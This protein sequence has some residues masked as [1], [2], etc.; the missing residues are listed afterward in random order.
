MKKIVLLIVC[1]FVQSIFANPAFSDRQKDQKARGRLAKKMYMLPSDPK[2][3]PPKVYIDQGACPFE[4]CV[5]REWDVLKDTVLYDEPGGKKIVGK[6]RKG[7]KAQAVTGE[8]HTIPGIFVLVEQPQKGSSFKIGDVL[9][10]L[11]NQGEGY[12]KYWIK[13]KIR[14]LYIEQ[15]ICNQRTTC[16]G[17]V[18][19]KK[20]V[21]WT[22]IKLPD[23]KMGWV[24]MDKNFH[25]FDN[26]DS[27]G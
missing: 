16:Y 23:G 8:V 4:C 21:W 17:V 9:Y 25:N 13:G 1:L 27:C 24:Q 14:S 5:Y 19:E 26:M 15:N 7:A 22:Q 20:S 6:L 12:V 18:K 10:P 11:T 3:L 2:E